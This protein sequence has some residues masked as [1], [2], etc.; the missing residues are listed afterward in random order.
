M[1]VQ[2]FL[3]GVGASLLLVVIGALGGCSTPGNRNG[4]SSVSG[5]KSPVVTS[6]AAPDS[7]PSGAAGGPNAANPAPG[8]PDDL[9]RR[10]SGYVQDMTAQ[11]N[12]PVK[13][14]PAGTPAP[15]VDSENAGTASDLAATGNQ[16]NAQQPAAPI[17]TATPPD[18]TSGSSASVVAPSAAAPAP[19]APA[20]PIADATPRQ[21]QVQWG[22]APA[23]AP[24][25]GDAPP[26]GATPPVRTVPIASP[27]VVHAVVPVAAA[28]ARP[29]A[30]FPIVLPE[31]ADLPGGS[32]D[33]GIGLQ[34]SDVLERRLAQQIKDDP[35]DTSA[36]LDF[37]LLEFVKGRAT[38]DMNAVAGLPA[39]DR[40]IVTAMMDALGNFRSAVRSDSN[41]L[42]AR[43]IRP[44]VEMADRLRGEADLTIPVIALCAKVDGFGSY[45]L[46]DS[47]FPAGRENP[48]IVYCEVE[49]FASELNE[50]QLW[51]TKLTQEAVLY[52]DTGIRVWAASPAATPIVDQCR[53]R[54]HDFF[55]I[56]IVHLPATLAPGRYLLKVTLTDQLANRVA[57]ATTQ[58]QIVGE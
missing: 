22:N 44:I 58:A 6:A 5:G 53:N 29:V 28:P 23:A 10:T 24:G 45:K 1:T 57:E 40:E 38:P 34:S 42:L 43:K 12:R 32:S 9:A 52:T 46:I 33:G 36:Q 20:R 17:R 26:P 37:Q 47:K 21:S 50:T 16:T 31:S 30:R 2:H 19:A 4:V 51:E 39:E 25:A 8:S 14:A 11:I 35:R 54:R 18:A 41:M 55:V 49:N 3:S 48:V 56:N 7:T 15:H 13:P 27:P